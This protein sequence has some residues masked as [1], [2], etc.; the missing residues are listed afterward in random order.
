[1]PPRYKKESYSF[2]VAIQNKK[3][4][5]LAVPAK[6][7]AT[8]ADVGMCG[9]KRVNGHTKASAPPSSKPKARVSVP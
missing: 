3:M 7:T 4:A 8:F 1:M 6:L 5:T 2:T 9:D